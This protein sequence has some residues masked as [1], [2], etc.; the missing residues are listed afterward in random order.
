M[1]S[2]NVGKINILKKRRIEKGLT[3]QQVA[4]IVGLTRRSYYNIESGQTSASNSTLYRIAMVLDIK[5]LAES[6]FL[7]DN[8]CCACFDLDEIKK[9]SKEECEALTS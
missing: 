1:S 9:E 6:A 4:D 2:E 8:I 3:Q 5:K 7:C